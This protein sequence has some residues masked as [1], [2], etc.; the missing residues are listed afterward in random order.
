MNGDHPTTGDYA[1]AEASR[2]SDML[3]AVRKRLGRVERHHDMLVNVV[4]Y[5][6]DERYGPEEE[7]KPNDFRDMM[8]EFLDAERLHQGQ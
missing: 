7:D 5:M 4:N 2:N 1:F 6:L 3:S 8:K